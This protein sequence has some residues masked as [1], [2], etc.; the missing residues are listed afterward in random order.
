LATGVI[1]GA[2]AVLTGFALMTAICY[3]G[4]TAFLRFGIGTDITEYSEQIRASDL[5]PDTAEE[6]LQRLTEL[7][8]KVRNHDVD[9]S[10]L[11]WIDHDE[12]MEGILEDG[13][14]TELERVALLNELDEMEAWTE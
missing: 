7:R 4:W 3:S 1:A 12:V 14:V 6:V 9:V 10:L 5:D 2:T 8:R 13:R 11:R